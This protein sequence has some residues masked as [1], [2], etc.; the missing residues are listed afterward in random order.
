[1]ATRKT[2]PRKDRSEGPATDAAVDRPMSPA[3]RFAE[4]TLQRVN[5]A[6]LHCTDTASLGPWSISKV[7]LLG[8]CPFQ[9]YLKYVLKLKL[10]EDVPGRTD[11]QSADIG[12]AAHLILEHVMQGKA[13]PRAYALAKAEFVPSKL[14]EEV[15]TDKV[16]TLEGNIE[17]FKVR[18]DAAE[19]KYK[20]KRVLTELRVAVTEQWE[21][22]GFFSKDVFLRGVID[23]VLVLENGDVLIIDHKTGGGEGS[24]KPYQDQLDGYKVLYYYGVEA[25]TVARTFIHFIAAGDIRASTQSTEEDITGKLR[26]VLRFT[27]D[28]VVDGLNETGFYKHKRGPYCKWCDYDGVCKPGYLKPVEAATHRFFEIHPVPR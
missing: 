4:A 12:T 18:M 6:D 8:K 2:P 17:A 26:D 22:T 20:I 23:L 13:L 27:I 24:L 25:V 1:M 15:W 19:A 16:V 28:G 21:P 5:A 7:K 10:P 11:T 3:E 9:F 14:T